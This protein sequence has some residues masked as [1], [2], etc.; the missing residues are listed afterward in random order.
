[1]HL[2][3]CSA[4]KEE[5]NILSPGWTHLFV[6]SFVIKFTIMRSCCVLGTRETVAG[7][8][9]FRFWSCN[10][11]GRKPIWT[12]FRKPATMSCSC[13]SLETWV[14]LAPLKTVMIGWLP[15]AGTGEGVG[16]SAVAVTSYCHCMMLTK[17]A[18]RIRSCFRSV[19]NEQFLCFG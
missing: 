12:S 11:F 3:Q 10:V 2:H 19:L 4:Q 7:D 14:T 17:A 13:F 6:T 18:W 8:S 15:I 5:W 9:L 1:M 16:M